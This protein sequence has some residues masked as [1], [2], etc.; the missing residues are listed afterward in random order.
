MALLVPPPTLE[1]DKSTGPTFGLNKP[2]E[3]TC[4]GITFPDGRPL[5]SDNA[6]ASGF[7]LYRTTAQ[8][9]VTAWHE[10]DPR[11]WVPAVPGP[12]AQ[13]LLYHEDVWKF[14]L[15]ALGE[16]D[17]QDNDKFEQPPTGQPPS[18]YVRCF[19]AGKDVHGE[20]HEGASPPSNVV[21]LKSAEDSKDDVAGIEF[22]PPDLKK[23]ET[24]RVFL[25][26]PTLVGETAELILQR[27][28]TGVTARLAVGPNHP[29][30]LT[31]DAN[32]LHV[33]GLVE[34]NGLTFP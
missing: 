7:L 26:H 30:S 25:K 24:V 32:G 13:P 8:G 9:T 1:Q 28:A 23:V 21:T 22:V 10:D 17:A 18:Y 34:V 5:V 4:T 20:R 27:T 11:A 6:L 16:K 31:L 33:A 3:L 14:I 12:E 15:V 19:F 29:S 2:I